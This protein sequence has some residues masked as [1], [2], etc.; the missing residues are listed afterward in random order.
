MKS[1]FS[2]LLL[3]KPPQ[4]QPRRR[5]FRRGVATVE[6]ALCLSFILLPITL[7]GFQFAMVFMTQHALQQISRES[8]RFAA[9]HYNEDTFDMN[10][11]Q[12][13]KAGEG[14]SLKN[15]VRAQG[16]AN[17]IGWSEISGIAAPDGSKGGITVTPNAAGRISGQPITITISY[18]MKR[19]A[20]LGSLFFKDDKTGKVAPLRL[21]FLQSNFSASSTTLME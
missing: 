13:N 11:N 21:G 15:F 4:Q 9:V 1:F 16:A 19:R 6:V 12:G 2:S 18:P 3:P 10:E 20:L 7:G 17:G 5:R 8:A 14:R